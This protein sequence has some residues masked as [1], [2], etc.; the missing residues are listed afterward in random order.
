MP[1]KIKQFPRK[2]SVLWKSKQFPKLQ[3]IRVETENKT[4]YIDIIEVRLGNKTITSRK[5][6]GSESFHYCVLV[7]TCFAQGYEQAMMDAA[8]AIIE[9]VWE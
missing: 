3:V 8:Q 1:R 5:V 9:I 6:G 4:H 7:S 2:E